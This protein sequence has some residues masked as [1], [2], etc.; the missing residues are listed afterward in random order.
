MQR[1]QLQLSELDVQAVYSLCTVQI[2]DVEARLRRYTAAVERQDDGLVL[3]P[4]R[5]LNHADVHSWHARD[6]V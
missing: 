2:V 5:Y 4:G 3:E 1:W 6:L